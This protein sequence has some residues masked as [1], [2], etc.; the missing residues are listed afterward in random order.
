MYGL[1][2]VGRMKGTNKKE[3][4]RIKKESGKKERKNKVEKKKS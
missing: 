1:C 3:S 4:S 2:E